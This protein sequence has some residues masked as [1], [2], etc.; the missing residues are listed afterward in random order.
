MWTPSKHKFRRIVNGSP[1]LTQPIGPTPA[2][3]SIGWHGTT[4]QSS[5]SQM[6]C[7]PM[8]CLSGFIRNILFPSSRTSTS[9]LQANMPNSA[10]LCCSVP[11][12]CQVCWQAR[13]AK[14][15]PELLVPPLP[16]WRW[17]AIQ[18]L[19]GFQRRTGGLG[20]A[21]SEWLLVSP[22]CAA[23]IME[24]CG[25][26]D[27][28]SWSEVSST[29]HEQG[30]KVCL[31]VVPSLWPLLF[32]LVPHS[33]GVGVGWRSSQHHLICS[34]WSHLLYLSGLP[35]PLWNLPSSEPPASAMHTPSLHHV[36]KQ[37][38]VL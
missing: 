20:K 19:Q 13:S 14:L 18:W 9:I 25:L 12:W 11:Q 37:G 7:Q 33:F 38:K 6:W 17:R 36:H 24:V 22:S 3:I 35:P 4:L 26:W 29:F 32:P 31:A 34:P 28:S 1:V 15:A 2:L 23:G 16:S 8:N 30:W 5:R 27:S 10:C 21:S